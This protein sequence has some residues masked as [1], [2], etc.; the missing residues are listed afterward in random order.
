MLN[1]VTLGLLQRGSKE[2]PL[3]EME[4]YENPLINM[5]TSNSNSDGSGYGPSSLFT[6]IEGHVSTIQ[7]KNFIH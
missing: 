6:K 1:E 3:N 2:L 4:I 7:N 5:M